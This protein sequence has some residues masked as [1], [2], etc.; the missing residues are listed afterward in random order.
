MKKVSNLIKSSKKLE[1]ICS[2]LLSICAIIILLEFFSGSFNKPQ[3]EVFIKREFADAGNINF[4]WS[5]ETEQ[6][7][8]VEIKYPDGI[9]YLAQ[10]VEAEAG[11]Q[12]Y[13]GKV[14]VC[15]CI[16]NRFDAGEYKDFYEVIN[17]EGQFACVSNGSIDC[18]P[19]D[20]TYEV[21]WAELK[22]RTNTEIL[23]F[24]TN[25]YHSFGEP[26]FQYKDHYFSK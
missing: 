25:Y 2:F 22:S 15:D 16:L 9:E 8:E 19:T 23:H 5:A 3:D 1:L 21:V 13:M 7:I 26:C 18:T 4:E 12:G 24:R 17:E 11:N 14:Y 20:E 6:E 10:C